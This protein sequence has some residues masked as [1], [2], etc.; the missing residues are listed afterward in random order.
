VSVLENELIR[1]ALR[2]AWRDSQSESASP[3]EEGGF[4][5]R[6][7]DG[8]L[9]VERW[10]SGAQNE[11][12]VPPHAGCSRSGLVIVATFHTHPNSGAD[13]Q[14]EPSLTDIRAVRND[15]DLKHQGYEGEYVIATDNVYVIRTDGKVELIGS[16]KA[17]LGIE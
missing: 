4:V 15:P 5:L 17:V 14:Q 7:A 9:S 2:L 6:N 3:Q 13:F 8:S 11:I 12:I 10:P 1:S 16:S